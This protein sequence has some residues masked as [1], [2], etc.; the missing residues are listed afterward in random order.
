MAALIIGK[1]VRA[2]EIEFLGIRDYHDSFCE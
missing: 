2:L 1:R